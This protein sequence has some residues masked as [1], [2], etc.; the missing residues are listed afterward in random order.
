MDRVG[1]AIASWEKTLLAGNSAFD[2]W[3]FGGEEDALTMNQKNG[4]AMFAG[5][6]GCLRCHLIGDEYALF[7]DQ[8]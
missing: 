5:K 4:F 8:Y 2:R 6:A 7:A 3:H 1:Q